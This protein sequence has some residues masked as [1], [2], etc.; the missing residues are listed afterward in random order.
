MSVKLIEDL[1]GIW[2]RPFVTVGD[3]YK[4][5][6][7]VIGLNPATPIPIS[8]VQRKD[9]YR[10][11]RNREDFNTWYGK[12][13]KKIGKTEFSPTRKCLGLI[14]HR[15]GSLR[16]LETNVNA[17]PTEKSKLLKDSPHKAKGAK[18][19]EN[20]L[21]KIQP[22]I[23]IIHNDEALGEVRELEFVNL[24][25]LVSV[26][27]FLDMHSEAYWNDKPIHAFSIPRFVYRPLGW[28][29]KAIVE[30]ISKIMKIGS[31]ELV[32]G[33]T[34]SSNIIHKTVEF[35][36][37]TEKKETTGISETSLDSSWLDYRIKIIANNFTQGDLRWKRIE[38][39][40]QFPSSIEIRKFQSLCR[41]SPLRTA[42][43]SFFL[44]AI[45]NGSI[46]IVDNDD[47]DLLKKN[48]SDFLKK[49]KPPTK[50]KK[51]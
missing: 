25:E 37:E 42:K 51:S 47:V 44:K 41:K 2:S 3:P 40:S 48:F 12:Y 1:G 38:L 26:D 16:V 22:N 33:I 21:R 27:P 50:N 18:I 14:I 32:K 24:G 39:F 17:F 23:V 19:A 34:D 45:D 20:F 13:R 43:P 4:V 15:L 11:I 46:R 49:L 10:L 28:N 8:Y 30:S 5:D 6:V 35:A 36:S 7:A 9:L 31:G 29:N